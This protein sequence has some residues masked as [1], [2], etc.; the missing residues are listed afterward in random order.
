M[1]RNHGNQYN[2]LKKTLMS[3]LYIARECLDLGD[4][5]AARLA[6]ADYRAG[7][8]QAPASTRRRWRCGH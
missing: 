6:L 8:A 5:N 7:Y 1:P 4:V 2:S 3:L